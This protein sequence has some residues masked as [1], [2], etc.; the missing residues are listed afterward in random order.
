MLFC[1][2]VIGVGLAVSLFIAVLATQKIR[3]AAFYQVAFIWTYAM[4]PAIAA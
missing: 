2:I 4:S 3:G 1:A